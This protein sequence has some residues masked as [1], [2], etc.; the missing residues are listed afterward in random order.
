M[1][2]KE[3]IFLTILVDKIKLTFLGYE[4]RNIGFVH[5]SYSC[6][7]EEIEGCFFHILSYFFVV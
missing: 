3:F 7:L 4:K 5:I 1:I 6:C 2:I